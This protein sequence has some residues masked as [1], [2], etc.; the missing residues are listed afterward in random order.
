[1]L[2]SLTESTQTLQ[3]S[4]ETDRERVNV[5]IEEVEGAVRSVKDN[6]ERWREEM[7]EVRGEVESIRDLVP[8]V[9]CT[10][11][12]PASPVVSCPIPFASS[13]ST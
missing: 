8:K 11:A 7:R 4:L 2:T 10:R 9:S 5:V 13:Q 1:M 12:I 3:A 6:E